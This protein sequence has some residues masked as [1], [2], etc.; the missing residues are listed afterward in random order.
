MLLDSNLIIYSVRPGH[1]ELRRFI[2]E[3]AP[4]VSAISVVEVLG[5]HGLQPSDAARFEQFFA[6]SR[7]LPVDDE[8]IGRAVQLR[9]AR[10]MTLGDAL[11][12]GTALTHR[13]VL[14]THNARDFRWIEGLT[15]LDPLDGP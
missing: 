15:L 12:A 13:L 5:Y 11:I 2:A 3:N 7:V 9:R 6:A 8:V 14:V 1:A 4:S 10:R